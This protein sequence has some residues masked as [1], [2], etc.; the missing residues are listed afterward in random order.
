MRVYL[1][2]PLLGLT[3]NWLYAFTYAY[4]L[5]IY[6]CGIG[7]YI[8]FSFTV[9][10][11]SSRES[12]IILCVKYVTIWELPPPLSSRTVTLAVADPGFLRG[13]GANSPGGAPTYDFA[14]I[15][16]KLHKI[17][18]ISTPGGTHVPCAPLRSATAWHP[19]QHLSSAALKS[20]TG[21][22][23]PV[24]WLI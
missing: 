1:C 3:C 20:R 9:V 7:Y 11:N 21:L 10:S 5:A 12:Y 24:F 4:N 8:W 23:L 6:H 2:L 16:Q 19:T 14:K 22:N 13:G 15:S 17:E 18:R